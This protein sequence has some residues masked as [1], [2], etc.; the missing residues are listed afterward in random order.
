MV[1]I[2]RAAM[3]DPLFRL[4]DDDATARPAYALQQ[5]DAQTVR[6]SHMYGCHCSACIHAGAEGEPKSTAQE[7]AV[8]STTG[9]DISGSVSTS[10]TI[11]IDESV[12]S[13]LDFVGDT[14]WFRI[15]LQAGDNIDIS[16][17]GSGTSPVSDTYLRLYD[18]DGNLIASNDDGGEGL[19]SFL[20]F[21]T[22]T[23]GTFYIEADSYSNNKLGEYTLEVTEAVPLELFTYDQ[24]ADQ[25]TTGFWG[26]SPRAFSLGSSRRITY[27]VSDLPAA[28]RNLAEE[29]LALWADITG[30]Q[31][32]SVS[33]GGQITFE[34]TNSGAYAYSSVAGGTIFSST[35]NV[36]A[37]WLT[38]YGSGLDSYTFQA[39]IHEV[40]HALGLGHAGNYNGSA[41]YAYD[42]Q[43]LNDSWS[44]TIMSYF[45]QSENTYFA[46]QGFDYTLI[47]TPMNGDVVAMQQLYGLSTQTRLGDTTYGFG[48]TAT[49]AVFDA[50]QFPGAAYTIIDSGGTD[51][52][53]YSGFTADQLIDLNPEAFSNI[54]G[55]TG[56]VT[57]ARG[58]IIENARSGE[59]ADILTGNAVGNLLSS[60]DGNDE[61]Y[62]GA[63]NDRLFGGRGDDILYGD[64]G[65]DLVDGGSGHDRIYG[66]DGNDT[67]RGMGG[68]DNI[69][70]GN[71][72]DVIDGASW[73]D[74]LHGGA[75]RDTIYGGRGH[76]EL[77]GDD[78]NDT[79]YGGDGL[80]R[81][82]GG[83]GW[84]TIYGGDDADTI[85]GG[86]GND[87]I[88]G[89]GGHDVID[90]GEGNDVI[91]GGDS[92]DRI[93][94]GN[95]SDTIDGGDGVDTINGGDFADTIHGGFGSD[96]LY[97]DE[98]NDVIFGDAGYDYIEGG[99]GWD[100]LY[101]GSGKDTLVGGWGNDTLDGGALDDVLH[102]DGGNDVLSGGSGNDLLTGGAGDDIFFFAASGS[103]DADRIQDF[104]S[105]SDS[106][107]LDRGGSFGDLGSL[108]ILSEELF[109][110][111][112]EAQDADDRIIYNSDTGE[113]W[114]DPDGNGSEAAR[115]FATLAP[116]T[117]I[118]ASDIE[119]V[120]TTVASSTSLSDQ[121]LLAGTENMVFG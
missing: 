93:T 39:Y 60:A 91:F 90:G 117:V 68:A 38:D 121:S 42:A 102:G 57:I 84:D 106:I 35:V 108:G 12:T 94:G 61:L 97:G 119:V 83:V 74:V 82:D 14:D 85:T 114:Y 4:Q 30:I 44:T 101:G 50:N 5:V 95:G 63:G 11:A 10:A 33:S 112:S 67:L 76:D 113:L 75:G 23:G 116:G 66:G 103:A 47:M 8:Q 34:D 80:D 55:L 53:D 79:L 110:I 27:D 24:I 64:A 22:E 70:G 9:T 73:E 18:A 87:T 78:G 92:L 7:G 56:N 118:E 36:S 16:L 51:T 17:F 81:I 31:F 40:G 48:S 62:G 37:T 105:G 46:D 26:G 19:N 109:H 72:N 88:Y 120:D 15:E 98:G 6:A 69:F 58:T 21:A 20:R 32:V 54:G 3:L 89:D 13:T 111:G 107:R 71:G 52:L 49:R 100:R 43:Y 59:G 25:L 115:L 28:A 1:V 65:D 2:A 99:V 96:R 45:S 77:Y 41:V 29:A 104:T 86:W